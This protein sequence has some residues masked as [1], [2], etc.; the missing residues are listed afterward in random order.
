MIAKISSPQIAILVM[1]FPKKIL[2]NIALHYSNV[3][4]HADT[5]T[6]AYIHKGTDACRDGWEEGNSLIHEV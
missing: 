5:C 4:M 1:Y 2:G 6:N 3:Q